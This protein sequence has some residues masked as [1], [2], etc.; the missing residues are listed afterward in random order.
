M[1]DDPAYILDMEVWHLPDEGVCHVCLAGAVMAR[2]LNLPLEYS[3]GL[4][5]ISAKVGGPLV[6][7][8]WFRNL[9]FIACM[10]ILYP[11]GHGVPGVAEAVIEEINYESHGLAPLEGVVEKSDILNFFA[12]NT[13]VRFRSLLKQYDL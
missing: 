2:T 5:R 8:D 12:H 11:G 10:E 7:L 1:A 13:I 4:G 9:D 3:D 6:A